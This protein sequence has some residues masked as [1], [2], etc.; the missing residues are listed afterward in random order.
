MADIDFCTSIDYCFF[1]DGVFMVTRFS[2][3]HTDWFDTSCIPEILLK[4]TYL[5]KM[6][7]PIGMG[8]KVVV[9]KG[10]IVITPLDSEGEVHEE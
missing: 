8:V 5:S 7:F 6:G 9:E 4:G 10:R 2:D 1:E 3:V